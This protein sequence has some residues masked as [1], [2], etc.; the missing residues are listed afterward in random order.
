MTPECY[1]NAG[2]ARGQPAVRACLLVALALLSAAPGAAEAQPIG[3]PAQTTPAAPAL[4]PAIYRA[5]NV[6]DAL[7]A[8]GASAAA[9]SGRLLL[10]VPDIHD[11]KLAVPV[12]M[13]SELPNTDAIVLIVERTPR[14]VA[15]AFA[16]RPM[17]QAEVVF[18]LPFARTSPVHLLVRSDGKWFRVTR[19]VRLA[20]E[21][22]K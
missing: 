6:K 16:M 3:Q 22:W 17:Q 18:Q 21:A 5:N 13:R 14:P 12:R 10:E 19:T 7:A 2:S 9:P 15:A 11:S 20:A 8:L 1:V 4:P